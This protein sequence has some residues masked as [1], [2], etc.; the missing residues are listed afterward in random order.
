MLYKMINN[1][2]NG[3]SRGDD[4]IQWY[5][6]GDDGIQWYPMIDNGSY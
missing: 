2:T 5:P 6:R 3:Y 1:I 4:G